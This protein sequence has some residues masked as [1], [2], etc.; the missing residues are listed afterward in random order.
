MAPLGD[1]GLEI[2]N[3]PGKPSPDVKPPTGPAGTAS[4]ASSK[5]PKAG[6]APTSTMTPLAPS[7]TAVATGMLLGVKYSALSIGRS[8]KFLL[9]FCR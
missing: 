9:M 3:L 2:V 1:P 6:S 8:K 4:D 5:K 7:A